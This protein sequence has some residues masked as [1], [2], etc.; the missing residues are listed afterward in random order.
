MSERKIAAG[1][2]NSVEQ[3]IENIKAQRDNLKANTH[4]ALAKDNIIA[5]LERDSKEATDKLQPTI[6]A[7]RTN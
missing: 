2:K 1:A 7:Y 5:T 3:E 6:D 4:S